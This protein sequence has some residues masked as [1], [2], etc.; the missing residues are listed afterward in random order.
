MVTSEKILEIIVYL[1]RW[2]CLEPECIAEIDNRGFYTP[3]L[4]EEIEKVKEY[5]YLDKKEK[6]MLRRYT[7]GLYVD[8]KQGYKEYLEY[9]IFCTAYNNLYVPFFPE[10]SIKQRG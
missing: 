3:E 6:R 7:K 10:E 2:N 4:I 8:L 9:K 1:L 5:E